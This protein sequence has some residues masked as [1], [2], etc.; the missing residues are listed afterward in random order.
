MIIISILKD[1]LNVIKI[2]KD[3]IQIK[4]NQYIKN[5]I[6]HVKNVIKKEI[7]RHIIV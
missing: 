6:I 2:Q 7:I 1:L 3:I 5:V 4:M